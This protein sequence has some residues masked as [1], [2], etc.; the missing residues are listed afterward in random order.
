MARFFTPKEFTASDTANRHRI[1]NMVPDE[2]KPTMEHTLSKLDIIRE[3]WGDIIVINSGYRSPELN[4]KIGGAKTSKHMSAEAADIRP[5]NKRDVRKLFNLIYKM[6]QEG[7]IEYDQLIDEYNYSW[8]HVSFRYD[9][10]N[11]MQTLHL[12]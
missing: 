7:A 4:V 12:K 3:R 10:K 11:R 1:N 6:G 5:R 9:G 2:L 8:V